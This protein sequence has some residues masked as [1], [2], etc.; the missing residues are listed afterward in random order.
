MSEFDPEVIIAILARHEDS[1][2]ARNKF[3]KTWN[4]DVSSILLSQFMNSQLTKSLRLNNKSRSG[5][6]SVSETASQST[7]ISFGSL[8]T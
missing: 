3:A 4:D 7:W 1:P 6:A 5:Q 2:S 8:P